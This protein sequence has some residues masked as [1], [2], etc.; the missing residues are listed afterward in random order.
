MND[1][2]DSYT[3]GFEDVVAQATCI[4]PKSD[5]SQLGLGKIVVDRHL[6]DE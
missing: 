6:V 3:A 5:F 2:A 1:V 4:Y